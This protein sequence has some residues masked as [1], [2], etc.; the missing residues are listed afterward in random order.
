MCGSAITVFMF[1]ALSE[2]INLYSK[3]WYALFWIMNGLAQST[4]W[5]TVV[6]IMV[7]RE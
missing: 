7:L 1:G 6:A 2:W 4:G 5:P 3:Y